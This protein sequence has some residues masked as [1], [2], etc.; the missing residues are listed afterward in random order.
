ME[1]GAIPRSDEIALALSK[2]TPVE[3]SRLEKAATGPYE[4]GD[5]LT[6]STRL[7]AVEL[8]LAHESTGRLRVDA[9]KIL[10]GDE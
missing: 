7:K 4:G 10:C 2:L 1:L 8:G 3:R 5:A 6:G 9:Y